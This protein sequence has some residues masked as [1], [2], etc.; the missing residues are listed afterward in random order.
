MSKKKR[1]ISNAAWHAL[2]DACVEMGRAVTAGEYAKHIGIARS[3]AHTW[4]WD[5]HVV[6]AVDVFE[7]VGKNHQ[8][9]SFYAPA[10]HG[11][12]WSLFELTEGGLK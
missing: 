3:T 1:F 12:D 10:G 5:M 11:E 8:S 4:L 2:T 7:H 6:G 9:V